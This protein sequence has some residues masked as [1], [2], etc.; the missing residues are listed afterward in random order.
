MGCVCV[1]VC[2]SARC[3]MPSG[4]R[5][6]FA[7]MVYGMG[8]VIREGA[9]EVLVHQRSLAMGGVEER[10]SD[11]VSLQETESA[12]EGLSEHHQSERPS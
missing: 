3:R 10:L 4:G 1:C 8:S 12:T 5:P 9:D 7:Q 2:V 6:C 11:A